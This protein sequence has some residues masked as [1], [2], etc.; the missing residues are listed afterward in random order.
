MLCVLKNRFQNLL[1][2]SKLS[3]FAKFGESSGVKNYSLVSS[4]LTPMLLSLNEIIYITGRV[5]LEKEIY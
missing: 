2:A 5:R 3:S 4:S 1:A